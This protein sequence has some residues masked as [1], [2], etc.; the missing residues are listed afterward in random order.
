MLTTGRLACRLWDRPVLLLWVSPLLWAG[1]L[2]LGRALGASYPPVSLAVGRWLVALGLLMPFVAARAWRQRDL[3]RRHGGLILAC[4][5][6][7]VAGYNALGYLAL[8]TTQAANVAFLN[9]TLPLMIPLAAMAL[10]RE[11]VA[12]RTVIGIAVSFFGVAWIVS[13]GAWSTLSALSF[14]RGELLVL[15][16]VAN[17]AVYSVLLRR[18]PLVLD[19]L[20]FLAATMLAGLLVLTPFWAWELAEGAR[21]PFDPVSVAAVLYIGVFASLIAFILWNRCVAMLGAAVTGVSF[22]LVAV[23][24]ALL[25]CVALHEQLHA[26]H[27][28]GIA[29]ILA[30][31]LLATRGASPMPALPLALGRSGKA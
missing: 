12:M 7:G 29:L 27:L 23:F 19:P 11:P 8:Q 4:G 9:S 25:A 5:A 1:N 18:R 28:I 24:T 3:L 17:Y 26:F 10:N 13:R 30:G 14:H 2:V 6:F 20:V 15:I 16:A 21:I 31:F 22:H